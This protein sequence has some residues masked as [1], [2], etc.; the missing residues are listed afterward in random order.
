MNKKQ[1]DLDTF[2]SNNEGW[3]VASNI[4]LWIVVLTMIA[5]VFI[6]GVVI[7]LV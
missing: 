7:Y 6:G 2:G 1:Q 3:Y 4:L 5:T